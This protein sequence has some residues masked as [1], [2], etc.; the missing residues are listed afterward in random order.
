[1]SVT[2]FDELFDQLDLSDHIASQRAF[3]SRDLPLYMEG[4]QERHFKHI[5]ALDKHEFK[6]PPKV[7]DFSTIKAHLKKSGVLRFEQ[8]FEIIKVVRYFR[9]LK[10]R[11]LPGLIGSWM[12]KIEI[13]ELFGEID[14][15][16]DEEGIFNEER[17][18]EL[19]RLGQRI[20]SLKGDISD[21][22][23]R[24]LNTAK[25]SSYLVDHQVHYL[26]DEECLLVRGGFNHVLKGSVIGRSSGGSDVWR[27]SGCGSWRRR[28]R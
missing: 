25:L 11:D 2:R 18:E 8:I 19:Y 27:S 21:Q 6:A 5:E 13:H 23:K 9:Y 1:M 10:N 26:N 24:M 17:D 7:S 20:K 28:P 3:F 15:Y 16:F 4:D 12:A 22:L 14:G